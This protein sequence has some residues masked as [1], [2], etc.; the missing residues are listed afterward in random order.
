MLYFILKALA[1]FHICSLPGS[2][3]ECRLPEGRNYISCI[4]EPLVPRVGLRIGLV[5]AGIISRTTALISGILKQGH[6]V[7]IFGLTGKMKLN[8]PSGPLVRC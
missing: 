2:P 8:L 7:I 6:L 5:L 4:E 1:L 3:L